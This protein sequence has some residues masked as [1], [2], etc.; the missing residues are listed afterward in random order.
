MLRIWELS[1]MNENYYIWNASNTSLELV[2]NSIKK[3]ENLLDVKSV[4]LSVQDTFY[5]E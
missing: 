5:P 3:D 4:T 1:N 2:T